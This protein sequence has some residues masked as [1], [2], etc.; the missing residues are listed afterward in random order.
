M[1][2]DRQGS[3]I[4]FV[5]LLLLFG[6]QH[7]CA[8]LGGGVDTNQSE[9]LERLAGF[10]AGAFS[11]ERQAVRDSSFYDVRLKMAPILTDRDDGHWFYVEQAMHAHLGRPYRQ[12]VYHL[13]EPSPGLFRSDV[14]TMESP[15]RFVGAWSRRQ[16]LGQLTPDSLG[17]RDG[18]AIYIRMVGAGVYRGGTHG[19]SCES[20]L[21]GASYAMSEVTVTE[22]LVASWD[23]GFDADGLQVWGAV[24]G[25]YIFD[26]LVDW[27]ERLEF[28]EEFP[29]SKREPGWGRPT[30]GAGR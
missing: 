9:E 15:R 19:E 24:S 7:G 20:S 11:S 13:T 6:L 4:G 23:R 16:P 27:S 18:C 5:A 14:Y 21:R 26:R 8:T 1:T 28:I 29:W 25:P 30:G 22:H 2:F 17:L 10:M 12:R 3:R